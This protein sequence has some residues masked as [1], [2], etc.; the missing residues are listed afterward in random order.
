MHGQMPR[1]RGYACIKSLELGRELTWL[2]IGIGFPSRSPKSLLPRLL[3]GPPLTEG[4][5]ASPPD[6][7]VRIRMGALVNPVFRD[8]GFKSTA[9]VLA[10][11][12][13]E[14]AADLA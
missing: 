11:R 5:G 7:S 2:F 10:F 4:P 14:E 6:R 12:E 9:L 13:A 1:S 3:E 8:E